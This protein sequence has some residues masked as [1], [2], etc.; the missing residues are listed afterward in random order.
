M[1]F[2]A[3]GTQNGP[4]RFEL[5][6]QVPSTM[7]PGRGEDMEHGRTG[8]EDFPGVEFSGV[9]FLA[10]QLI[11]E[12]GELARSVARE[13]AENSRNADEARKWRQVLSAVSSLHPGAP[14]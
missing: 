5:P 10:R 6:G 8:A 13:R 12:Y 14:Q 4:A 9:R 2:V 1:I 3:R 11:T 7:P